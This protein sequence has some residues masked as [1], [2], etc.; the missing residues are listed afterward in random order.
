MFIEAA[1]KK[2]KVNEDRAVV[3]KDDEENVNIFEEEEEDAEEDS[4][5]S[6]IPN[7]EV[8]GG[9]PR[10]RDLL[11]PRV[12][13]EGGKNIQNEDLFFMLFSAFG[14]TIR[15]SVYGAL[16]ARENLSLIPPRRSDKETVDIQQ[17]DGEWLIDQLRDFS[18]K[19]PDIIVDRLINSWYFVLRSINPDCRW[20]ADQDTFARFVATRIP[21]DGCK[22]IVAQKTRTQRVVD[23]DPQV[24]TDDFF[25]K[26]EEEASKSPVDDSDE[27]SDDELDDDKSRKRKRVE[28]SIFDEIAKIFGEVETESRYDKVEVDAGLELV[29]EPLKRMYPMGLDFA[30]EIKKKEAELEELDAELATQENVIQNIDIVIIEELKKNILDVEKA[31]QDPDRDQVVL[32][33]ELTDLKDELERLEEVFERRKELIDAATKLEEEMKVTGVTA[34]ELATKEADLATLIIERSKLETDFPQFNKAVEIRFKLKKRREILVNRLADLKRPELFETEEN[35]RKIADF[36]ARLM[37][38][39][40]AVS[41]WAEFALDRLSKGETVVQSEVRQASKKILEDLV[42]NAVIVFTDFVAQPFEEYARDVWIEEETSILNRLEEIEEDLVGADKESTFVLLQEKAELENRPDMFVYPEYDDG[43]LVDTSIGRVKKAMEQAFNVFKDKESL[44]DLYKSYK[45]QARRKKV[46]VDNVTKALEDYFE[47]QN[48]LVTARAKVDAKY[49]LNQ[50]QRTRKGKSVVV[51]ENL[52]KQRLA[53][54]R[55]VIKDLQTLENLKKVW[56]LE[57]QYFEEKPPNALIYSIGVKEYTGVKRLIDF[58]PQF[59]EDRLT[60]MVYVVPRGTTV[61]NGELKL[62]QSVFRSVVEVD[63]KEDWVFADQRLVFGLKEVIATVAVDDPEVVEPEQ[64][65]FETA[66]EEL[67]NKEDQVAAHDAMITTPKTFASKLATLLVATVVDIFNGYGMDIDPINLSDFEKDTFVD[68][69]TEGMRDQLDRIDLNESNIR[70]RIIGGDPI[71]M[72]RDEFDD[73]LSFLYFDG[74]ISSRWMHQYATEVFM[75]LHLLKG[76]FL[77]VNTSISPNVTALNKGQFKRGEITTLPF[78]VAFGK[79]KTILS[80]TDGVGEDEE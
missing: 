44:D 37:P 4:R 12:P 79:F 80:T 19:G 5:S 39:A 73:L 72:L 32:Q 27:Y 18:G 74:G 46:A 52:V 56:R 11:E 59:Y 70:T 20:L 40:T 48:K 35:T 55:A 61:A 3:T 78:K 7:T 77:G 60:G 76:N 67:Q 42:D 21:L 43:S 47:E 15:A 66:S 54:V 31:L 45:S 58:Q 68:T 2:Q 9:L 51:Q 63:K 34:E 64:I 1:T 49:K 65:S 36:V 38:G 71:F 22:Y 50:R 26:E 14:D 75:Q 24:L 23:F 17:D 8:Y 57:G 62:G 30:K 33:Q 53:K 28:G 6:I 25:K 41:L 10:T 69:I 16:L 29:V 13:F